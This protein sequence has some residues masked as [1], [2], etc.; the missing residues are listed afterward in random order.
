M[1]VAFS[2]NP[3]NAHSPAKNIKVDFLLLCVWML[4]KAPLDKIQFSEI[5]VVLCGAIILFTIT[6]RVSL[7]KRLLITTVNWISSFNS[8]SVP[9]T[10][11]KT[12]K[13]QTE[14]SALWLAETILIVGVFYATG[15]AT[16]HTVYYSEKKVCT[17]V[18]KCVQLIRHFK[19]LYA[20]RKLS[21]EA[22]CSW[23]AISWMHPS[24]ADS[25]KHRLVLQ[26]SHYDSM[27]IIIR[28]IWL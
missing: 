1:V 3:S 7:R 28:R 16:M 6:T 13:N 26:Y 27:P 21:T 23:G 5:T 25:R 22:R 15:S 18:G 4:S 10:S 24:A 14:M 19:E 8:T 2:I 17:S 12:P 11:V 20:F 9:W